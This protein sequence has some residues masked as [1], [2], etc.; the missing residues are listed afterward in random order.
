VRYL[1][2]ELSHQDRGAVVEVSLAGSAS[3]VF[4]VDSMN[5]SK[6][7]RGATFTYFGGHYDRSPVV[8]Q[9]PSPGTWTAVVIP[10]GGS[11]RAGAKI[12]PV[13]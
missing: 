10:Q 5:F 11:V 4:L 2:F 8:L 9:V 13:P 6:F 12:H 3:D 1:K 7:E